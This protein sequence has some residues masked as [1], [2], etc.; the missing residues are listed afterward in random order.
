MKRIEIFSQLEKVLID[1]LEIEDFVITDNTTAEEIDEW[2]SL[3]HIQIVD[4]IEKHFNIKFTSFEINSWIDVG[5]MVD[6]V[7]KKIK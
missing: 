4:A 7:Q 6:C 5:E 3:S 2:D 1:I